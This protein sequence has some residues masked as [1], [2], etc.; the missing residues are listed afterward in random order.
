M[1]NGGSFDELMVRLKS[2]DEAAET[3]VFRRYVRRVIALASQ[4]F[5]AELRER[6]DV[7]GIVQSACKS[8][9]LRRVAGILNSQIG[10]TSGRCSRRSPSA[11]A[12]IGG[13]TCGRHGEPR[14]ARRAGRCRKAKPSG[15]R[16]AP[17]LRLR[18][19]SSPRPSNILS[20]RSIRTTA[21]SCTRSSWAT[22][23]WKWPS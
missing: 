6:A 12:S 8:F 10:T 9:F 23:P 16:I 13:T 5:E 1:S 15:F 19:R 4:Q 2:G 20:S 7:E 17:P 18:R 22:P 3:L 21:R 11:N 14:D